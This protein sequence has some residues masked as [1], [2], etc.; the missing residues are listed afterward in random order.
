MQ[1]RSLGFLEKNEGEEEG[2]RGA[3]CLHSPLHLA[4]REN[5]LQRQTVISRG[6]EQLPRGGA[7]NRFL[8]TGEQDTS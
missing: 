6:A 3:S 8:G 1:K 5:R 2:A 7:V 4:L